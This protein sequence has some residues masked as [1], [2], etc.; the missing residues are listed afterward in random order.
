MDDN[1]VCIDRTRLCSV[2]SAEFSEHSILQILL[3][4]ISSCFVLYK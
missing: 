3:T 1:Y 4:F 2:R